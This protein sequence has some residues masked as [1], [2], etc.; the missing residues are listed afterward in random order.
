[1][2]TF[3]YAFMASRTPGTVSAA[4]TARARVA[5]KATAAAAAAKAKRWR[6]VR[7]WTLQ[8]KLTVAPRD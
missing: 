7:H 8:S 1:M 3:T 4:V 2:F 5:M 6:H